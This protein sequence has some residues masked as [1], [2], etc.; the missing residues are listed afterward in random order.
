MD[1][2]NLVNNIFSSLSPV[3]LSSKSTPPSQRTLDTKP[4][5]IPQDMDREIT[6]LEKHLGALDNRTVTISLKELAAIIPRKRV[7][8]DAY[9]KLTKHLKANSNTTLLIT[10]RKSH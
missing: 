1:I 10:S 4:E 8:I 7:R 5:A 9:S 6:T 3:A 2:F